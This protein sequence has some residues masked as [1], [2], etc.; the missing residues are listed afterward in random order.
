MGERVEVNAV[1]ESGMG[2][3]RRQNEAVCIRVIR[4]SQRALT[5]HVEQKK[6]E[7]AKEEEQGAERNTV[8]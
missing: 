4:Q 7:G 1:D 2:M 3:R 6:E 5:D 8:R